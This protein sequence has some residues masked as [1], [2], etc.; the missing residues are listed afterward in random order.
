ML[1]PE[2]KEFLEAKILNSFFVLRY[3]T[4]REVRTHALLYVTA[5]NDKEKDK[6]I[7]E[8]IAKT[9]KNG[10]IKQ[11]GSGNDAKFE[12]QYDVFQKMKAQTLGAR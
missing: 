8:V 4:K 1:K 6:L 3:F 7:N 2:E 12:F 9:K 10:L 5:I 11:Q